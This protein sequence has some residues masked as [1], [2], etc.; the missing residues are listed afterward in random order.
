MTIH[1]LTDNKVKKRGFMAEH[2]LSIFIEYEN[3][4]VL[5]DTG[6]SQ[7]YC[8]NALRM[9]LDLKK[10]DIIVLSHGHYDHCGGLPYFPSMDFP[11]V[12]VHPDAFEK[13]YAMNS[14]GRSYREIGI[15][16]SLDDY[17]FIKSSV[18]FNRKR[19]EIATG[20]TICAEIPNTTDF[21]A[22]PKGFYTGNEINKV[23]DL[24]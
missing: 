8:S 14:D 16:W 11:S 9:G 22:S 13:R 1:I 10:T 2:G 19:T 3:T 23:A 21:E 12:Y 15:P 18:V 20:I 5:F 17:E 6:Q 24:M 4:K 7:I